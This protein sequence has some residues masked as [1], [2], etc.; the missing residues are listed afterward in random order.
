M[1]IERNEDTK[2]RVI[3]VLHFLFEVLSVSKMVRK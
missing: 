2:L 3:R 1:K